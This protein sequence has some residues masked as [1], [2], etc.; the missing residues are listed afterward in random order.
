MGKGKETHLVGAIWIVCQ[1]AI[2]ELP[3]G[4]YG[5]YRSLCSVWIMQ[6]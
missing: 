6:V 2:W 3:P 1:A 5:A 4:T